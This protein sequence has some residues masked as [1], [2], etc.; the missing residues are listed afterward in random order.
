MELW[1]IIGIS[2]AGILLGAGLILS[3]SWLVAIGLVLLPVAAIWGLVAT[4]PGSSY[5]PY[6]QH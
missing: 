4:G 3:W 2:L 5:N 1:H 6:H